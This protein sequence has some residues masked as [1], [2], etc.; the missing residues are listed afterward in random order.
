MKRKIVIIGG[1]AGGATA[2]AR[3]RRLNEE[4]EIVIFEKGEYISFANCGLP[5]YIG[6]TIQERDNLLLET[7]GGMAKKFN[8]DIKNF[9][10]VI[11]I[12]RDKK[13]IS[14]KNVQTNTITEE[15]YDKLII[16]TGAKP[17]KP[18]IDGINKAENVFTL[19]N[20]PDMDKIKAYINEHQVKKATVIGGGFIGLE[21][22]ENLWDLGIQV[23]LVEMSD[24]VMAPIDFEMAQSVHAHID[25]HNV[26]L[27]LNDGVK[28]FENNGSQVRLNS[29]KVI[30]TDMTILSIGVMPENNLALECKFENRRKRRHRRQRPTADIRSGYL[31]GRGCH[32][33]HRLRQRQP[34]CRAIGLAG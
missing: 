20:I 1:V 17:I 34:D 23:S 4:D 9:S 18:A 27:I 32:R 2:A 15:S 25:M 14:V 33:S 8:V 6:G 10:E 31:C 3:L 13:T 28:A 22:M 21:M 26:Q 12:N 19:R 5:Y 11:K 16:S 24:Q 29:G 7:V 30:P